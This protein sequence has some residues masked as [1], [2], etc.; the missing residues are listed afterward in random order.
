LAY[1]VISFATADPAEDLMRVVARHHARMLLLGTHRSTFGGESLRGVTGTLLHD[2]PSAVGILHHR[3]LH[4]V[5]TVQTDG[6][7]PHGA[8]VAALA[9]DLREGGVAVDAPDGGV[10]DLKI[11]GFTPDA[12][13]PAH[14]DT[15]LLLVRGAVAAEAAGG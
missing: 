5:G 12:R 3:G 11:R 13:L 4:A 9:A 2:C 14:P 15:S 10:P 1:E 8:A 7:G 6:A